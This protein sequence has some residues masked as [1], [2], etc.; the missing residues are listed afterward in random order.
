ML[1]IV[2]RLDDDRYALPAQQVVEVLPLLQL[3]RWP[4]APRGVAG[5]CTYRGRPVPVLDLSEL[6]LGR[7]APRCLSTRLLL[8]H[9]PQHDPDAPTHWL[10]L[11]AEDATDTARVDAA[12]FVDAGLRSDGAPYLGP[13]AARADGLL[14]R[15]DIAA[16]LPPALRETLFVEAE[17]TWA[18]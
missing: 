10:G 13:V 9:Y 18:A 12:E 7:S 2:F 14:Q 1:Y 15:L 3:K 11:I 6:C 4:Q 17:A 16:L 8:L 5:I